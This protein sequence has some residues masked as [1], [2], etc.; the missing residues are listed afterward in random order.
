MENN[1]NINFLLEKGFKKRS[2]LE[3]ETYTYSDTHYNSVSIYFKSPLIPESSYQK[4]CMVLVMGIGKQ[5]PFF[6]IPC[7][8]VD[9]FQEQVEEILEFIN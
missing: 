5:L 1:N 6:Y 3:A 7:K 2:D 9:F 4:Y 8:C